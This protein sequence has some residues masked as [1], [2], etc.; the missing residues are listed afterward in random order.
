MRNAEIKRLQKFEKAYNN[1]QQLK[2]LLQEAVSVLKAM[3][4]D[5]KDFYKRVKAA[6]K[7]SSTKKSKKND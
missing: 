1:D 4:Y 2:P 7:E 3:K 5:N 6:L